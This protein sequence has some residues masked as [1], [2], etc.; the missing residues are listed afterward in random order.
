[1]CRHYEMPAS[2][3]DIAEERSLSIHHPCD[4]LSHIQ[5]V[6]RLHHQQ[7][8]TARRRSVVRPSQYASV[9]LLHGAVH[10]TAGRLLAA[11]TL[12]GDFCFGGL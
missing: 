2:T 7:N 8:A 1:V 4:C 6:N 9:G 11:A 12:G 10:L 5:E 3:A